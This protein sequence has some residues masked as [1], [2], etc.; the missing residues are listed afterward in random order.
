MEIKKKS[1]RIHKYS[2]GEEIF[3]SIS[4]GIGAGLSVGALVFMIIKAKTALAI[5]TVAIFGSTMI[6]LYLISCIYHALSKNIKG[7]KVLR[8]LDHDNVYLLVFGTYIPVVLLGV[9][10]TLGWILFAFVGCITVLGIVF[11]SIDIDRYDKISVICHLVNGWSILVAIPSLFNTM[12]L[13]GIIYLVL[14]GVMYSVGALIYNIGAHVKYMHSIFHMFCL[15]GSLFHF[16]SI[17]F[18]LL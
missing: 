18:Y 6:I 8:V 5:S 17:Y 3:N 7:K 2:L 11:T 12:G 14:G 1:I 15:L 16:I 13:I 9:G 10:N 4:H